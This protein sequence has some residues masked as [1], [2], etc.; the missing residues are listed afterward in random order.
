[1][2]HQT[3]LDNHAYIARVASRLPLYPEYYI[4]NLDDAVYILSPTHL[5]SP[6]CREKN[7]IVNNFR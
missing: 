4:P 1:M 5:N 6:A 2:K 7:D 3:D